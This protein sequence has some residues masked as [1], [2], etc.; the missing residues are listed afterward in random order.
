MKRLLPSTLLALVL[1]TASTA[2]AE[3]VWVFGDSLSD[4][5]N[6]SLLFATDGLQSTYLPTAYT[7][8]QALPGVYLQ[9]ISNGKTT[10]EYVADYYGSR[11][12]PSFLKSYV[13]YAAANNFAI[14]GARAALTS[15][16]DLPYQVAQLT[17]AVFVGGQNVTHDRAIV[18]L[19]AN[20]VFAAWAAAIAPL[21]V[22]GAID[23]ATGEAQLDAAI[24]SY[25]TYVMDPGAQTIP[26]PRG[27]G[28]IQVPSIAGLGI[29]KFLVMNV[30]DIG[31]TPWVNQTAAALGDPAVAEAAAELTRYFNHSLRQVVED[32]VGAGLDVIDVDISQINR[33]IRKKADKLGFVN[34]DD[35]C[36]LTNTLATLTRGV[37]PT[38]GVYRPECSAATADTWM[39]LDTA[40]PTGAVH[41]AIAE[42]VVDR[43]E[44][45]D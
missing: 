33:Q 14:F 9:R 41:A 43:L 40:H 28:T 35:D 27:G 10:I 44:D 1:G 5:G 21:R 3:K 13:G 25:R 6:L 17:E 15:G 34:L 31:V 23:L 42:R 39:F 18:F 36:F 20:D 19:G 7:P 4:T 26:N 12:L 22:G 45:L 29:T 24:A 11:L 32:M 37:P 2:G 16:L 30:P 38:P 8:Y